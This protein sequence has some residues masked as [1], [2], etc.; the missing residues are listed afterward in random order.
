MNNDKK[1]MYVSYFKIV[2]SKECYVNA[3]A[4]SSGSDRR[5][6]QTDHAANYY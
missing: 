3:M 4:S 5:L 1:R 2:F 6:F